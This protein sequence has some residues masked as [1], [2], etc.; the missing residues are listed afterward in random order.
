MNPWKL[1]LFNGVVK[2]DV[3]HIIVDEIAL[4]P[5]LPSWYLSKSGNL[6]TIVLLKAAGRDPK[7]ILLSSNT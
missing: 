6:L 7:L 4:R 3:L 2:P 1:L 5:D